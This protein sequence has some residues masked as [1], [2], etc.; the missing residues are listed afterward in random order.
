VFQYSASSD[1]LPS[2]GR[3]ARYIGKHIAERKREAT[4][5]EPAEAL[6]AA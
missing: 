6:A 1:V 2:R 4:S 3:D 5:A